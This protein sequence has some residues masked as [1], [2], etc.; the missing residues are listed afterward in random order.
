[1]KKLFVIVVICLAVTVSYA[2]PRGG[3]GG[4]FSGHSS[5]HGFSGH[6]FGWSRSFG[7]HFG[8]GWYRG[9]RYWGGRGYYPYYPYRRYAY[10]Y[11]GFYPY[12]FPYYAYGYWATQCDPYGRC[13]RAWVPYYYY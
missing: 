1:M 3:P 4:G 5:G 13:Y 10:P 9:G 7:G 12:Y 2:Y 11:F 8:G 6:S